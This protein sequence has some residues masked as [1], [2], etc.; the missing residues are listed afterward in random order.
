MKN[1]DL[2]QTLTQVARD[3]TGFQKVPRGQEVELV[4]RWLD[5]R[6]TKSEPFVRAFTPSALKE[7][8]KIL[9]TTNQ[10]DLLLEQV[11]VRPGFI[12]LNGTSDDWDR[13]AI[14]EKFIQEQGYTSSLNRSD[15]GTDERVHFTLK[16]TRAP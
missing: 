16:G 11:T 4:N 10:H 5:E 7:L 1:K 9:K 13:S 6:A 14:L 3:L 12:S 8:N 15:A 2:Q